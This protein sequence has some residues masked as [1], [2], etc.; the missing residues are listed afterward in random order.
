MIGGITNRDGDVLIDLVFE[1]SLSRVSNSVESILSDVVE[2]DMDVKYL[3]K[4]FAISSGFD[5]CVPSTSMYAGDFIVGFVGATRFKT[6][7]RFFTSCLFSMIF[8]LK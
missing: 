3:L 2:T 4:A 6:F 5:I 8:C 7:H 1:N